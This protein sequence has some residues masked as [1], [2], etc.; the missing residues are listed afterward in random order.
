MIKLGQSKSLWEIPFLKSFFRCFKWPTHWLPE[1]AFPIKDVKDKRL[2]R[3]ASGI[4]DILH[5]KCCGVT[6]RL[7]GN[8]Y[9]CQYI[10]NK[11]GLP[12][13]QIIE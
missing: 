3:A 1:V 7:Q 11:T 13:K 10:G 5:R 9:T 6:K 12:T 4:L 2:R 8:L